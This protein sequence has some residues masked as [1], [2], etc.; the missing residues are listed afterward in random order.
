MSQ[1][2]AQLVDNTK[3]TYTAS[4]TGAAARTVD[5][6]L[7]DTVS[8]KDFGAVGD[9]VADDTAAVNAAFTAVGATG[10]SLYV[11][12]GI[13]LISNT[14]TWAIT[15]GFSVE[16]APGAI[17]KATVSVPVDAKLFL[18]TASS[19]SQ[20]FI[21]RGGTIDGRLMPARSTGAPDLLYIAYQYITNV[22]IEGVT[23]ICNDTRAGTAGDS[24]LFLAEGEDYRVVGNVFQ[25][26][27]DAGVYISGNN[28]AT[29][30]R[31]A[32]V[33]HN[34]FLECSEVGIITKR[35][36]ENHIF[37]NNF[38]KNCSSGI[39]LGGAAD[40]RTSAFKGVISNNVLTNCQTGISVRICSGIT[41][42]G[43]RVEDFGYSEAGVATGSTGIEIGGADHCTI[44]GNHIAIVSGVTPDAN[45][46]GIRLRPR[47]ELAVTYQSEY[48]LIT[49]NTI[50]GCP[51]GIIEDASSNYTLVGA[52][53]INNTTGSPLALTGVN[54]QFGIT[55]A[56]S[57]PYKIGFAGAPS[58]QVT[59][60]SGAINYVGIAGS[61]GATVGIDSAGSSTDV[62]LAMI[63]KGAGVLLFG[64]GVGS[65]SLRVSKGIASGNA[66]QVNGAAAASPPAF[67]SR[68]V[69]TDID[70]LFT[71]KGTGLVRFGTLFATSDV[72]I[73][74]Y[75]EIKDSGGTIRRLAVIS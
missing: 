53:L 65:E 37:S 47:T 26:A 43:N 7:G 3:V 13:Y 75:I 56:N 59:G 4:G 25:G 44:V 49:S 41:V 46:T 63:P 35:D 69:D 48:N 12:A 10:Q 40:A 62:N 33:S 24:C 68:G 72:P 9:G 36:F 14:I 42:T 30:G 2:K 21:W 15:N 57:V 51:R 29:L 27:V 22:D 61:S 5:S 34:T 73:T 58:L 71:P 1:T 23:F 19:N 55:A 20:R 18:P 52:N 31:R 28:G 11:P 6:K 16:C 64:G 39:V 67:V 17:F 70:L 32:L 74:G 66:I 38:L 45:A 50:N 60:V 8:V 54:S